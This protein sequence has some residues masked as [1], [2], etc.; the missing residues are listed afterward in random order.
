MIWNL[1]WIS[2]IQMIW[3]GPPG[4]VVPKLSH[5]IMGAGGVRKDSWTTS[6]WTRLL[7]LEMTSACVIGPTIT[8]FACLE[9][10]SWKLN[11]KCQV[12]FYIYLKSVVMYFFDLMFY[13]NLSYP[14]KQTGLYFNKNE[15]SNPWLFIVQTLHFEL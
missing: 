4:G 6:N 3:T 5:V 11:W 13:H 7:R 2:S 1:I 14:L 8:I 9:F 15:G 12:N 10:K